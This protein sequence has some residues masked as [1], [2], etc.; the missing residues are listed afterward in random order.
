MTKEHTER[1]IRVLK[2][3]LVK[4]ESGKLGKKY[5]FSAGEQTRDKIKELQDFLITF[6]N[7]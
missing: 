6:N 1:L 3:W 7:I 4:G 5:T 2:A